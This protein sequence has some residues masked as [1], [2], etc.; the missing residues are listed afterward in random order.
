MAEPQHRPP[1]VLEVTMHMNRGRTMANGHENILVQL[2]REEAWEVLLR[3]M[4]SRDTDGPTV[5][6][7]MMKLARAAARETN[8]IPKA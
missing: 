1:P 2:T 8:D 4:S 5:K 7:A 3:C 6:S